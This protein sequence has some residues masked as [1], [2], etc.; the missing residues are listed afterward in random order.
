MATFW[1]TV[2]VRL[3][4]LVALIGSL[5]LLSGNAP[6]PVQAQTA[7]PNFTLV[8]NAVRHD[9]RLGLT[10]N[11]RLHTGGAWLPEKQ[12]VANGFQVI[13]DWQLR[14]PTHSGAL[15]GLP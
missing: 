3:F 11:E 4:F 12:A 10:I 8:G 5:L 13:F 6:Q 1:R 2:S 15:M 7:L 14:V 9:D